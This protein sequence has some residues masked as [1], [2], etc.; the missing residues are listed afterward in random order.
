MGI[1][2]R[3]D[4]I[5]LVGAAAA[6]AAASPLASRA[7][8]ERV[9]RI[10]V[11]Y[12]LAEDDPESVS[13][14][15]ALE[16]GL[17]E[18]GW[19]NGG[20]VRIDYRWAKNDPELIRKFTA[21]LI[22]LAPDVILTSGSLA[23]GPV[24]RATRNI[25]V[26]FLQVVDPVGSGFIETMGHPGGNVTGFTQFE[27]SLAGKWLELLKEIAPNLTRVAVLRD[28]TRGPGIGQFAV[29]QAMAP[30]HLLELSPINAGDP[31]EMERGIAVIARSPNAGLVVTVGGTAVRRDVIVAAAAK[32]R[33]PAIYPYRYFAS[34]GGLMSYG[35]D[36]I[37]PY[38]RAAGYVDR[39]FKG[40]KPGN[41][42]VQAP[43]KY[44][45]AINLK[46]A[47]AL[48]L[49]VPPSLLAR[50]DEVIE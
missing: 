17:N 8:S 33:V 32:Y 44:Q 6:T 36:T 26:V 34:D 21:E 45:L 16:R 24:V 3:R 37:E 13:R 46:T 25:P 10:G 39:I 49:T 22:A 15:V 11:L 40:E 28:A 41:L 42:P 27:Y 43:T 35:P 18:L 1:L 30:Q 50:A 2:Q 29:I 7:Q 5:A 47:K 20:N 38:V 19:I 12:S 14:R 4:F 23:V 9:R 31:D 48:G